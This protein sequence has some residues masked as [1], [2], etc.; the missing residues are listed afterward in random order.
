MG[1]S[2]EGTGLTLEGVGLKLELAGLCEMLRPISDN[3]VDVGRSSALP[4]HI[5]V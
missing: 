3:K 5:R 4:R 1:L 2:P